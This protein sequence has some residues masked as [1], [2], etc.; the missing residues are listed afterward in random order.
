MQLR[1]NPGGR[2]LIQARRG[3]EGYE[4]RDPR[5]EIRDPRCEMRDPRSEIRDP[6]SE[7]RDPRS[8]IPPPGSLPRPLR[9]TLRFESSVRPMPFAEASKQL[10][11]WLPH[12]VPTAAERCQAETTNQFRL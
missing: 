2:C 11:H 1:K 4:M 12:R 9:F 5:S 6:R 3:R 8:E 7:I 10:R